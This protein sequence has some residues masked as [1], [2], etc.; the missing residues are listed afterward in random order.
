M[1]DI[2]EVD[3]NKFFTRNMEVIGSVWQQM[4]TYTF[5]FLL[6]EVNKKCTSPFVAK[7]AGYL[8][9]YSTIVCFRGGCLEIW[10]GV[11]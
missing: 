3:G 9:V 4:G 1:S 11:G 10:L 2:N 7:L 5:C 8:E 6:V